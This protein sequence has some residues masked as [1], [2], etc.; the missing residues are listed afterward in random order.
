MRG[1]WRCARKLQEYRSWAKS[2]S[3]HDGI[4][5]LID[6]VKYRTPCTPFV[7]C[8]ICQQLAF[9]MGTTGPRRRYRLMRIALITR[10][11]IWLRGWHS[12]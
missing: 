3:I 9:K 12:S 5:Q 10:G 11:F 8:I 1:R 6:S 7:H 2:R 4:N